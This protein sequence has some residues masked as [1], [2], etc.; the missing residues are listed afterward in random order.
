MKQS[1]PCLKPVEEV[2]LHQC[3]LLLQ[4][5]AELSVG[6]QQAVELQQ[7][8]SQHLRILVQLRLL[9]VLYFNLT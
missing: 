8:S 9:T 4:R 5:L 1:M 3:V 6:A 2:S 7:V